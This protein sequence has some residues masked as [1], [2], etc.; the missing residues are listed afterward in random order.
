MNIHIKD[1][2]YVK[3]GTQEYV[4]RPSTVGTEQNK[5]VYFSDVTK[6]IAVGFPREFCLNN[7]SLFQ[8]SRTIT[9]KE[10]SL[11]DVLKVIE[12]TPMDKATKES[13]TYLLSD[14]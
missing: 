8:V 2:L 5:I 6:N 9:D 3:Q 1:V 14:L 12:G 10:V 4:V 11:R 7:P 13:L